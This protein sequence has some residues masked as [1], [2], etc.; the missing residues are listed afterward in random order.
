MA[1][2]EQ[3]EQVNRYADLWVGDIHP[4]PPGVP[5][6]SKLR[7]IITERFITL[8]WQEG[9]GVKRMDIAID[10]EDLSQ[11]TYAGTAP[12]TTLA[13]YEIKRAQ[14]CSTCGAKRAQSFNFFPGVVFVEVIR[15]DLEREQRVAAGRQ[16]TG[17]PS[18]RYTRTR[19]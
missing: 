10:G 12:G 6:G 18:I 15:R 1:L 16:M 3:G 8:G 7:I 5:S 17:L 4:L 11:V 13:G 2:Y 19:G 14:K 9:T